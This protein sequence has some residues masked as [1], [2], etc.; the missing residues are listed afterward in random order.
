MSIEAAPVQEPPL[1]YTHLQVGVRAPGT[2]RL[3]HFPRVR[4]ENDE[5]E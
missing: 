1:A 3:H 5:D 4:V 2:V